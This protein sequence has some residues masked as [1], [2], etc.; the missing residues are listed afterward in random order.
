MGT[1]DDASLIVSEVPH[2]YGHILSTKS[3]DLDRDTF[4]F[5]TL[6]QKSQLF[7]GVN[8]KFTPVTSATI[9]RWV[10]LMNGHPTSEQFFLCPVIVHSAG[11]MSYYVRPSGPAIEP[12]SEEPL[13][14]GNYGWYFDQKC[15]MKGFPEL[16]SVREHVYTFEAGVAESIESESVVARSAMAREDRLCGFQA[17]QK[18]Q[19]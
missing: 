19:C 18:V 9:H 13:P 10:D 4:F 11:V 14:P 6:I 17:R 12:D 7:L 16:S 5:I 3:T 2:A 15:T 8:Q 1:H